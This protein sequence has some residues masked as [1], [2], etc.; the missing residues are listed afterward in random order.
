MRTTRNLSLITRF[1]SS[2][3]LPDDVLAASVAGTW[4]RVNAILNV[5]A[6]ILEFSLSRYRG[7][8]SSCGGDAVAGYARGTLNSLIRAKTGQGGN[9]T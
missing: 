9:T 5:P 1:Y 7:Y 4:F 8:L 2:S 3:N 6:F